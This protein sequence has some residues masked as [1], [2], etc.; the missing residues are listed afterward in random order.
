MAIGFVV[1]GISSIDGK[2]ITLAAGNLRLISSPIDLQMICGG[3]LTG[4]ADWLAYYD[5]GFVGPQKLIHEA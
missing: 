4:G 2:T 1:E 5:I 3:I